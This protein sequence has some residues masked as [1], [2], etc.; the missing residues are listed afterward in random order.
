MSWSPWPLKPLLAIASFCALISAPRLLP[1]MYDWHVYEWES[2]NSVLD[3]HPSRRSTEPIADAQQELKPEESAKSFLAVR[4]EDP[5]DN[6]SAFYEALW[7]TERKLPGAVT[8]IL[9]Y[10]DS[11]TTADLITADVRLLLQ[12]HFGDAGHGTYLIAKPWAWYGHAGLDGDASGW[13]IEPANQGEERDGLYGLGGVSFHGSQGADSLAIL[14]RP[15]HTRVSV[16]YWQQPG[17]GA[18]SLEANGQSLGT[19]DTAGEPQ[20]RQVSFP[21]APGATRIHLRVTRGA[22]RVFDFGF[23]KDGP[24]ILYDSLGLNGAYIHVLSGTF[25]E[26]NWAG[27]LQQANPKLVVINYGTNESVYAKY[28]DYTMEKEMKEALRRIKAALPKTSILI[29][30]PMDRGERQAGG[31]IGTPGVMP[32]LVGL[33]EKVAREN[34]VAFFNTFEAMGGEGTMGRWY[35]AEPRL[36]SADFIHPLPSGAR[37]VGTL[38]YKALLEGYNRHKLKSIRNQLASARR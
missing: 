33:Q 7:N 31:V 19:V 13:K 36:V 10:G 20:T 12:Q 37:I 16:C 14:R 2:I 21:L 4:I 38:F 5:S 17:G 25:S 28:V 6:M 3:F 15:G 23:F 35:H 11:P 22:V 18:F 34:G 8:R 26:K 27:L 32:R 1:F 24:G 9:H 30:S 29:M